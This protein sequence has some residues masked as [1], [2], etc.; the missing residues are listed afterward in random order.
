MAGKEVCQDCAGYI[1]P[2]A[3]HRTRNRGQRILGKMSR[4]QGSRQTG[5]LHSH[6]DGNGAALGLVQLQH[7]ADDIAQGISQHIMQDYHRYNQQ[8][9][10]H[11]VGGIC[12]NHC[13]HNGHNR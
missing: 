7:L 3:E 13:S 10:G 5:I 6:L 12:R 4:G 2:Y 8:A 11:Q 9:G 1:V